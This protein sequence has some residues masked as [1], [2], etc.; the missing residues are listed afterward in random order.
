VG[1][2]RRNIQT[3]YKEHMAYVK[4]HPGRLSVASHLHE[5]QQNTSYF[6]EQ[7]TVIEGKRQRGKLNANEGL[8]IL[9]SKN[10]CTALMNVGLHSCIGWRPF[11]ID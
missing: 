2:T 9:R 5:K 7:F 1:Q 8:V 3:R 11:E 4:K 10:K 6:N